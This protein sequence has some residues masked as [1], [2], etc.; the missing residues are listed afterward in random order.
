MIA[1]GTVTNHRAMETMSRFLAEAPAMA[2]PFELE[3]KPQPWTPRWSRRV[4][5]E[6]GWQ[7]C[8]TVTAIRRVV[9]ALMVRCSE[10]AIAR[11]ELN[12]S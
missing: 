9:E 4:P 7:A 1:P 5:A 2:G 10:L 8:N 3:P 6:V 12:A 11:N